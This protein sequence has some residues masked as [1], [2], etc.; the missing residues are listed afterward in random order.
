MSLQS[1]VIRFSNNQIV[2]CLFVPD[3]VNNNFVFMER[4]QWRMTMG[5]GETAQG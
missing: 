2:I 1:V 5:S 3:D 4:A